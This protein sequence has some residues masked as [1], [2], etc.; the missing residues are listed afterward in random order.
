MRVLVHRTRVG[1]GCPLRPLVL[2]HGFA[3]RLPASLGQVRVTQLGRMVT[4]SRR[5]Q[6]LRG[7]GT[8]SRRRATR[9]VLKTSGKEGGSVRAGD[10]LA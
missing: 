2:A 5:A 10:V 4:R 7:D 9:A 8:P 1:D 6:A 3:V